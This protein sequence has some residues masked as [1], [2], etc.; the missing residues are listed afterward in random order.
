MRAGGRQGNQVS[1]ASEGPGWWQASDGKWYPPTAQPAAPPPPPQWGTATGPPYP[2]S[3]GT[4]A[5]A[6]ASLVLSILWLCGLG[7]VLAVIFG[8]MAKKQIQQTGEQG[9]GLA[10][11]GVVLGAIGLFPAVL[12]VLI[13]FITL[14]G[15]NS[16]SKFESVGTSINQLVVVSQW[17]R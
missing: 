4:N 5:L 1:D 7:S 13:A 3:S 16:S 12:V 15:D 8:G 11:A 2:R 9:A 17:R 10:T 6:I 14:L